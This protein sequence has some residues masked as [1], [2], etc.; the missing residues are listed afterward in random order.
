MNVELLH[1]DTLTQA[2]KKLHE[3]TREFSLKVRGA[4]CA[5]ALGCICARD[6]IAKENVPP[7]RRSTVD[8]YAIIARDSYGAGEAN[9]MFYQVTGRVNIE[10]QATAAVRMG[11]A[12]LVQTGSMVPDGATA[13][14]MVEYTEQ[15]ADGKIIGYQAVSENENIV[16]IG[17]DIAMGDCL[18]PK[19]K[20]ISPG[21]IGTM[22]ALGICEIA[23]F[24]PP[25]VT[26]I[27]TGDE[28]ADIK[29]P[30][31]ASKIRDIN[32][33]GLAAEAKALGMTVGRQLRIKDNEEEIY[34]AVL[35][36]VKDSDIV[37]L[38]GGSSKGSKDYTK[39]VLED[40]T[41]NVFTH[42][43]S[44]K[45]GKPTILAYDKENAAVI[46]GLP[47][48][49]MAAMLLFRLLIANWYCEKSGLTLRP[50]YMARIS[51]NVSSNQGRET[52]LLVNLIRGADGF[53]AK[54]I[55]AKSGSIAALGRADGYVLIPR[56][57]EGLKKDEPVWV[58]VLE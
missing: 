1:T 13:V 14:L 53:L 57:K 43:I 8:G 12:V 30:L 25:V 56:N 28:L 20:R 19:G 3:E 32:T 34:K 23:V 35:Q 38:S 44:I 49:P 24:V 40:I 45:P 16:Q 4:A 15:Y 10:E 54:P 55:H 7:F 26:V 37:L 11:E 39:K 47:G 5:D 21:D 46:A 6:V 17:E 9:P 58:E 29:E 18:I 31:T 42:G 27:S 22:A 33:Y 48:H 52:C 51:E 2:R 50:P 41:G 36:S